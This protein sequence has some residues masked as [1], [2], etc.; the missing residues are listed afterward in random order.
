MPLISKLKD[1]SYYIDFDRKFICDELHQLVEITSP[2]YLAL[3]YEFACNA[4]TR[5]PKDFYIE[6]CWDGGICS[7]ST[8]DST[9][10]RMRHLH[11]KLNE[12]FSGNRNGILYLGTRIIPPKGSRD[13]DD[14]G[15]EAEIAD[16]KSHLANLVES[17]LNQEDIFPKLQGI[18]IMCR[19]LQS[20]KSKEF[21]LKKIK[22]CKKLAYQSGKYDD[23]T[24]SFL[25]YLED[26]ISVHIRLTEI[27]REIGNTTE[28]LYAARTIEQRRR[29]HRAIVDNQKRFEK[30]LDSLMEYD[31]ELERL[32]R[33][34]ISKDSIL[35]L[36]RPN[37][38]TEP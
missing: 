4:G 1:P 12:S 3:L 18:V 13:E 33:D 30:E 21:V 17:L 5:R 16:V 31:Q 34:G 2:K 23:R 10:S 9:Y 8:W 25:E 28:D 36:S 29:M 22:T 24:L 38:S 26:Y 27:C 14:L 20:S 15:I 7:D 32:Q 35:S 19:R 11:E 6:R 37:Y